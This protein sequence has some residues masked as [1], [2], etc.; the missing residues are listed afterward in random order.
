MGSHAFYGHL[1]TRL[2]GVRPLEWPFS[3]SFALQE[4][5]GCT[6]MTAHEKQTDE[7][8]PAADADKTDLC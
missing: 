1:L 2:K 4:T 5:G 7:L 8:L 6:I 3:V